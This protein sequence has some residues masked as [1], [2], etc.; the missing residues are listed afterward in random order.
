MK[1]KW[2]YIASRC[3]RKGYHKSAKIAK[4]I[5]KILQELY[6][7][8]HTKAWKDEYEFLDCKSIIIIAN[9]STY[10]IACVKHDVTCKACDFGKKTGIC[11]TRSSL[12]S[13]FKET[14][15]AEE[16]ESEERSVRL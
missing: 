16:V 1:T 9:D 6:G 4:E 8:E 11:S 15:F 10:C 7:K 3:E 13:K 14:L 12:Y 2:E 5:D